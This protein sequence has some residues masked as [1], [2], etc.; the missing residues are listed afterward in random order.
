MSPE[1]TSPEETSALHGGVPARHAAPA[2]ALTVT[3]GGE[4][5]N[6]DPTQESP[7]KYNFSG[8]LQVT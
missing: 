6:R 8:H 1:E 4:S 2:A 3:R 5:E 7:E